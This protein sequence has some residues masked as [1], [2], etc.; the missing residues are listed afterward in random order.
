MQP[1]LL[2]EHGPCSMLSS[3]FLVD[4]LLREQAALKERALSLTILRDE[5]SDD[6]ASP[7]APPHTPTD[8]NDTPEC[9]CGV[10]VADAVAHDNHH[11][12]SKPVLKF[13]VSAILGSDKPGPCAACLQRS[14]PA[15]RKRL[16]TEQHLSSSQVQH[17]VHQALNA[18]LWRTHHPSGAPINPFLHSGTGPASFGGLGIAKPIAS[19]PQPTH[20]VFDSHLQS[21]L[22]SCRHPYL[23]VTT[24]NG[25][26]QQTPNSAQTVQPN[27][28]SVFPLAGSFPWAGSARGK[29]RRGMMRRAVF[30]DL[31][32]KGLERRFQLQKYISKPD[33]KKLAEKLGLKD[34]Q[35]KIWFQNRR[36]KWRNSKERE[37]LAAGGSREQTLPNKNNPH[38]D[39]SDAEADRA[40]MRDLGPSDMSPA[41]S[42]QAAGQHE[43]A[44]MSPTQQECWD[45]SDDEEINVT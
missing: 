11:D 36:M 9:T 16:Y 30:S 37:L 35:V 41:G 10:D 8:E 45:E 18:A 19:R 25:G 17:H 28:P 23:T 43:A 14:S 40:R 31:Q 12:D 7:P 29:P 15:R 42:P 44:D 39:L 21:F 20:H 26:Q 34:S 24:Q 32:R 5:C 38:P 1:H 6:S 33:R 3:P 13:S 27:G 22:A 4:N 2:V